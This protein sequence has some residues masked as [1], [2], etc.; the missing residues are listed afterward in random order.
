MGLVGRK[1][2]RRPPSQVYPIF[3]KLWCLATVFSAEFTIKLP[4]KKGLPPQTFFEEEWQGW[5]L[6]PRPRAYESPALPLSYLASGRKFTMI[7]MFC[8]RKPFCRSIEP[9]PAL[10]KRYK[11]PSAADHQVIEHADIQQF[12]RLD[13]GAGQRNVLRAGGGVPAWVVMHD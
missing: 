1:R 13:H 3:L 10:F 2:D 7:H 9:Q 4:A 11:A 6:N 8:Q 5:G 12:T